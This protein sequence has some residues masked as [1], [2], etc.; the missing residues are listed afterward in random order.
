M[1]KIILAATIVIILLIS[2]QVATFKLFP[3]E[4]INLSKH[5]VKDKSFSIDVSYVSAGATTDDVIQ[6]RK[7]YEDGRAEILQNMKDYNNFIRAS[8][9]GDSLLRLVVS[10]TG[11]YE[12]SPDTIVVKI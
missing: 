3:V 7:I 4:R 8:L 10:D 5:T 9:I 2:W 6:V 11:Y 12:R 1:R